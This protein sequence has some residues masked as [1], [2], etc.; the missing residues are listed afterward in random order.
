MKLLQLLTIGFAGL[1]AF[2]V[3][4][5]ETLEIKVNPDQEVV[6]VDGQKEVAIKIDLCAPRIKHQRRLPLNL[7][8]VLD[9]SGSMEGAKLEQAKQA[10]MALVNQLSEKDIFSLVAYDNEVQTLIPAQPVEDKDHIKSRISRIQAGGGTAL[11]AGVEQ[12]ADQVQRYFSSK[13]INRVILLSD[14]LANIGPSSNSEIS[15]LGRRIAREGIAV[16]T[17]GI[18]DDYN[19]DLMASLA[20]ASDANYYYVKDVEALP[21]I[22]EKELG[23]LFSIVARNVSLEIALAP[24]V[25]AIDLMGRDE[26][27]KKGHA[28]INLSHLASGQNRYV[29]LRCRLPKGKE[30]QNLT[31][32]KIKTSFSDETQE[33]K[34]QTIEKAVQV[35]YTQDRKKAEASINQ[36]VVT[37]RELMGNVMARNAAVQQ[38]DANDYKAAS[39]TLNRQKEKLDAAYASAPAAM[40]PKIKAEQQALEDQ[41]QEMES[42]SLSK[43]GRKQMQSDIYKQKNSKY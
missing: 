25:E 43:S 27:F 31:V 39:Q 16:T 23:E 28:K 35:Q 9:R 32:A 22:F 7:A 41:A 10:A 30:N 1:F 5:K 15:T 38:A 34:T 17:M 36:T 29:F 18:G 2:S 20:E 33:G 26:Q 42:G 11:Y 13:K 14:G 3:Q 37:E 21:D 6:L 24:E 4:A 19:E 40:K 8:V 12:G